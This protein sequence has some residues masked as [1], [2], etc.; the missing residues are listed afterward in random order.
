VTQACVIEIFRGYL[1]TAAGHRGQERA[2]QAAT[3]PRSV[4]ITGRHVYTRPQIAELY[5]QHRN[6]AYAGREADWNRLENDIIAAGR[7]GRVIGAKDV[8]GR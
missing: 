5:K 1:Q 6:G 8:A 4:A 7:E 3:A 2:R